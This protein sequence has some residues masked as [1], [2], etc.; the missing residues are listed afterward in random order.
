MA[1]VDGSAIAVIAALSVA[2][3]AGQP[4]VLNASDQ[5]VEV[6]SDGAQDDE[7]HGTAEQACA[8]HRRSARLASFRCGDGFC[9]Q[10]VV[11][12]HCTS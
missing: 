12:F 2:A 10:R 8:K 4:V 3:C 11:L 7:V 9:V 6:P 5:K 1:P